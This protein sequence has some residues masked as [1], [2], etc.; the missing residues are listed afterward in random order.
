[1]T[2]ATAV[3]DSY[4][5]EQGLNAH[6]KFHFKDSNSIEGLWPALRKQ[7]FQALDHHHVGR[8]HSFSNGEKGCWQ[9]LS[10]VEECINSHQELSDLLVSVRLE[11]SDQMG[12][13]RRYA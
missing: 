6:L 9:V 2:V 13:E 11:I 10:L 1:M 4:S 7:V 5:R 3:T 8:L 12:F